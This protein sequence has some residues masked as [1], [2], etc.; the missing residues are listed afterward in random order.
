MIKMPF[1]IKYKGRAALSY[2]GK[3][4]YCVIVAE[5]YGES[6]DYSCL[7]CPLPECYY[8]MTP[9]ERI[10]VFDKLK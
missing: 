5:I 3:D 4:S 10:A 9:L 7:T 2:E 8:K 1:K 6:T